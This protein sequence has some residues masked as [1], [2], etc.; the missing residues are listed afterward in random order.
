MLFFYLLH[1][2]ERGPRKSL[3]APARD[4][5]IEL[6]KWGGNLHRHTQQHWHMSRWNERVGCSLGEKTGILAGSALIR[7]GY[8]AADVKW[9]Q[10]IELNPQAAVATHLYPPTL[11]P[12][13]S[14]LSAS[15]SGSKTAKRP[16]AVLLIKSKRRKDGCIIEF[17]LGTNC[18]ICHHLNGQLKVAR[19]TNTDKSKLCRLRGCCK[20]SIV[21]TVS[22]A[23]KQRRRG[24]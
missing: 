9:K 19:A 18:K 11:N 22:K 7:L 21:K 13:P 2:P 20:S 10:S 14:L 5:Y 12:P 6:V 23:K 17:S 4:Y 3:P 8:P 24:T 1:W 16:L 15:A